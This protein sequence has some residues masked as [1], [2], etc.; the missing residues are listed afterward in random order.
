MCPPSI[1]RNTSGVEQNGSIVFY[2]FYTRH[3]RACLLIIMLL[4]WV[5]GPHAAALPTIIN[6][7]Y[8]NEIAMLTFSM[9]SETF[10]TILIVHVD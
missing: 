2:T 9:T 10:P 4:P 6:G 1:P 7:D 8:N 3:K 5:E